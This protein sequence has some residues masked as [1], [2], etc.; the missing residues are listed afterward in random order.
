MFTLTTP[1]LGREPVNH[2]A[3]KAQHRQAH[4]D[5]AH[6]IQRERVRASLLLRPEREAAGRRSL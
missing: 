5:R 3:R 2:R 6:R 1:E 4:L